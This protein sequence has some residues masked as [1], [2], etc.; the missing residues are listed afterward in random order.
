MNQRNIYQSLQS[1]RMWQKVNFL[2]GVKFIIQT[3]SFPTPI[4]ILQLKSV[5]YPSIYP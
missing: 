2:S 4:D 1:S 5:V 3:F